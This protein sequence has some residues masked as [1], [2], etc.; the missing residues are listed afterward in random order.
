MANSTTSSETHGALTGE[1]L[2]TQD[3]QLSL[4]AKVS[5]VSNNSVHLGVKLP[6]SR[7]MV[8]VAEALNLHLKDAQQQHHVT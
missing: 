8:A 7:T 3:L 5:A 2:D 1:N 4:Q 6:R